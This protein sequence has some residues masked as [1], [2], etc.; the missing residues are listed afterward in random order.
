M[1]LPLVNGQTSR[2]DLGQATKLNNLDL[3]LDGNSLTL[4]DQ[5]MAAFVLNQAGGAQFAPASGQSFALTSETIGSGSFDPVQSIADQF[6]T[7]RNGNVTEVLDFMKEYREVGGA[8]ITLGTIGAAVAL[9]P[10]ALVVGGAL[11]AL[12]WGIATLVPAAQM[13]VTGRQ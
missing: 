7:T 13:A 9:G 11:G 3:F 8:V 10:P 6:D 2:V 12:W 5:T 1:I 4:L